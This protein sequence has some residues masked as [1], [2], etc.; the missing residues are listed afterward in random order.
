M[1]TPTFEAFWDAY[2]LQI[3]RVCMLDTYG[4]PG[5]AD[6]KAPIS[7]RAM[8]V[9]AKECLDIFSEAG[10]FLD[11]ERLIRLLRYLVIPEGAPSLNPYI[12][13]QYLLEH[14]K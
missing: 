5:E 4:E 10:V 12:E 14:L 13:A 2:H 6:N 7:E 8:K 9:V 1:A 11:R 3:E